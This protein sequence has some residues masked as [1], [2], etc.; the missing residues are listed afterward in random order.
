VR[1][2][3]SLGLLIGVVVGFLESQY[4]ERFL[5]WGNGEPFGWVEPYFG[6]DASFYVF[7]LPALWLVFRL[8]FEVAV[9]ATAAAVLAAWFAHRAG[10]EPIGV[11]PEDGRFVRGLG[12]LATGSVQVTV[13]LLSVVT[14]AGIWL[15]RYEL[16][17]KQNYGSSIYSGP[18]AVDI[19]GLFSTRNYLYATAFIALLQ[20]VTIV[21]VLRRGRTKGFAPNASARRRLTLIIA[22]LVII[23]AL[24]FVALKSIVDIRQATI[25]APRE[26][27]V[28]LPYIDRHIQATLYGYG[29]TD[30]EEYEW[31][32]RPDDSPRQS[33]E[34]MLAHPAL[35]NAP[36]WPGFATRLERLVDPQHADRILLT[37]G[38]KMVYGPTL[39][40]LG[41]RQ[42]LRAYYEFMDVATIRKFEDGEPRMYAAAVRELPLMEPKP[43]LSY[44][45]QRYALFTHGF[46]MVAMP[47]WEVD[48][49]GEPTYVSGGIP[50]TVT[51]PAFATAN[52]R[53]Y[54]GFGS[55]SLAYTNLAG[56]DE[57]D[58]ATDQ[59]RATYRFPEDVAAGVEIDSILKRMVVGWNSL[60]FW[61]VL[62]TPLISDGSRVHYYRTPLERMDKVAPFLHWDSNVNPFTDGEE[63]HWMF[64]GMT[65][66]DRFPESI[67]HSLGD[68][69]DERS[70]DPQP[71]TQ[72]NY[73]RDSVKA[74][75]S[76]F[77]GSVR[78]YAFQPD[79]VLR[80]WMRI[81]PDLF[82]PIE[83]MP[84]RHREQIQY[85]IQLFHVQFDDV[86]ILYHMRD[87][88][89]FFNFE[90][91]WD[92]ANEVLGPVLDS[93]GAITFSVEPTYWVARPG[94]GV[95]A[96]V[97]SADGQ[98]A[99][100]LL[101]T[102]EGGA[103]NTR[104][105]TTVYM[106]GEDY[107]RL[108]VLK[109]PKS[110]FEPG[111]EQADAAIDQDPFLAAQIGLW[112][113]RGIEVIRGHTSA[114]LVGDE[115]VYVEPLFIRS[116]QNPGP[117]MKL[118][119]VVYRGD[120][121]VG[122]TLE[123]ALRAAVEGAPGAPLLED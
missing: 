117:Q 8:G 42:Q 104:A 21:Y 97:G 50:A 54:Y 26:P 18:S 61:K 29:L 28:Q 75:L 79:P 31:I 106:D 4:Y 37:S 84:E 46:G 7:D 35:A 67:I 72:A 90:D 5:L 9:V 65:T 63:I 38:D 66:S 120:V 118:I 77:D 88:I 89:E 83:D 101:F 39:E 112:N 116:E 100:S 73:V 103:L 56:I 99:M 91:M 122:R 76:A 45:G 11:G 20:G 6:R 41:Q 123:E 111:T 13:L 102:N 55:A 62:F 114:L 74:T 59:G 78:L 44:F 40:L 60:E 16:L 96:S 53:V 98:F 94:D 24:D 23:D 3:T 81:F 19:E 47:V 30:V 27:I 109:V 58:F 113:R 119:S 15:R 48:E 25:I 12:I 14:A 64:N 110:V 80:A 17:T 49:R 93:G 32:P 22:A 69:S 108:S 33:V 52:E 95:P 51:D 107:G 43:W 87:P 92:D 1:R 71:K 82:L 86:Y 68:K 121:G 115:L 36:L 70:P 105:F 85:P 34:D 57:F 10:R 2:F